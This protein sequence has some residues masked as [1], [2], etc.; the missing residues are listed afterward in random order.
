VFGPESTGKSTLAWRLSDHFGTVFVP[1]YA[2]TY[3]DAFG[4]DVSA[5][6]LMRIAYGQLA[7]RDAAARN[8]NRILFQDTDPVLTAVWSRMLIGPHALWFDG[9]RKVA[10]FYLLTDVD[11]PWVDDGTRY[12]PD[13]R[14]RRRFFDLCRAE[15]EL[16]R[17]PFV[18]ISG[19]WE[20]RFRTAVLA[21]RERFPDLPPDTA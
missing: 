19:G 13:E 16:R 14:Q 9:F 6:D 4:T 20:D 18:T 2:R 1:E 12:F 11:V 7:S 17:L 3:T 21:I 10:D 8:A 15:L 5:E